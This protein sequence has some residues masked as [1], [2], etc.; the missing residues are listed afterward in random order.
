MLYVLADSLI[1]LKN[2]LAIRLNE[3][4]HI[5]IAIM[6]MFDLFLLNF[7]VFHVVYY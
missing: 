3:D 4:V 2:P 5:R 6:Y 7:G 1:D